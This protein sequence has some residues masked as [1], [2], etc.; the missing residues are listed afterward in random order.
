MFFPGVNPMQCDKFRGCSFTG[1]GFSPITTISS[2]NRQSAS[3]HIQLSPGVKVTKMG[4]T[5]SPHGK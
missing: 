5:R 4:W 3:A 1:T 2:T